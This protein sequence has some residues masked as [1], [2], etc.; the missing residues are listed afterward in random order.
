MPGTGSHIAPQVSISTKAD[1]VCKEQLR[2]RPLPAAL[3]LT[4]ILPQAAHA[5]PSPHAQRPQLQ[6]TACRCGVS[7]GGWHWTHF[8][9]QHRRSAGITRDDYFRADFPLKKNHGSTGT[10]FD[11]HTKDLYKNSLLPVSYKKIKAC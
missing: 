1:I 2:L 10:Q 11:L 5:L 4:L 8:K 3:P 7:S 9:R 6:P